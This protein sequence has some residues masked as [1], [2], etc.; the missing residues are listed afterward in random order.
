MKVIVSK[1]YD[2][3]SKKAA[4]LIVNMLIDKPQAKFGFATGSTP[5]GLYE[6]LAKAEK[7]GEI[8]F[9]Y[10]K[11]VNLDEYI[12]IDKDNDQS[13]QYFMNENLFNKVSFK[14]GTTHLPYAPEADEKYAKEYDALLDEFGQ[15]DVQILGLGP[16]GHL[17]FNEPAEK[18]NQR[19]SII[20]LSDET[21]K[22]NS[23][24]FESEEDVP[25]YAISM[26]MADVFNAKMLVVLASGKNKHEVVKRIIEED[27][28]YPEFPASF[29]HLH[30]NVYLFVDEDAYQG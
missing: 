22:A 6:N 12:G 4:D 30:P 3:M 23:R 18:L 24:F 8:S 28:I 25:K 26:G 11:S 7:E 1:D 16:N 14:E 2:E 9:K 15:R 13:Y 29:L 5:I 20:K 27:T 21:I 17:A 19:T 10:S